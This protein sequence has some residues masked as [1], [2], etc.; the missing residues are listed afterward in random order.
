[1][2]QIERDKPKGK[3][4]EGDLKNYSYNNNGQFFIIISLYENVK[5][6]AIRNKRKVNVVFKRKI[7]KELIINLS[8]NENE[9][10]IGFI[11][12]LK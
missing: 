3:I 11:G 10:L 2:I 12:K 8:K 5:I 7:D 4:V 9:D 1:M 6:P